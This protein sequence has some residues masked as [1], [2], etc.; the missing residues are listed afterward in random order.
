[1]NRTARRGRLL[2]YFGVTFPLAIVVL[3]LGS[4]GN[5]AALVALLLIPASFFGLPLCLIGTGMLITSWFGANSVRSAASIVPAAVGVVSCLVLIAL[6]SA[7][8]RSVE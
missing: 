3:L 5:G 1:M 4:R 8:L 6:L 2:V 7:F